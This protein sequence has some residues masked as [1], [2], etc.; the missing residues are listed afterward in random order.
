MKPATLLKVTLLHGC[1][2][3]ILNCANYTKSRNAWHIYKIVD[4]DCLFENERNFFILQFC[5][6]HY[7]VFQKVALLEI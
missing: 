7:R 6:K 1:F 3:H 4:F 2:S 5:Q